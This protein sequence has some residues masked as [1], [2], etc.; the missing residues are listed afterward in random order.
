[1]IP[2]ITILLPSQCNSVA[3]SLLRQNLSFVRRCLWTSCCQT[4]LWS[5]SGL[6]SQGILTYLFLEPVF[7]TG[8]LTTHPHI[9]TILGDWLRVVWMYIEF[10]L[11][12][13][14]WYTICSPYFSEFGEG[15]WAQVFHFPGEHW[16]TSFIIVCL[17]LTLTEI[18]L[19]NTVK[20]ELYLTRNERDI[21]ENI[22]ILYAPHTENCNICIL[23]NP[24]TFSLVSVE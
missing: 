1:M 3:P 15:R 21:N 7:C 5:V 4:A 13:C 8:C 20:T 9:S 6:R 24:S 10:I 23:W 14:C 18:E 12:P 22:Q 16:T 11:Q 17:I 19:Q 2:E